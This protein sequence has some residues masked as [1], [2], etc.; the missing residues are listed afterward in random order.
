MT[1]QTGLLKKMLFITF[2]WGS[3]SFSNQATAQQAVGLHF[4]L[5]NT[6]SIAAIKS[7]ARQPYY[8]IAPGIDYQHNTSDKFAFW[9]SLGVLSTGQHS[10]SNDLRWGSE[11]DDQG[12]WVPDPNLPHKAERRIFLLY[13]SIQAGVKYYLTDNRIRLFVQPYLEGDAFLSH[14]E[15]NLL[16]LDNGDLNSK[17]SVTEPYV[18]KQNIVFAT[19]A[20]FGGEMEL[21]DRFSLYLLC[22]GKF[23]LTKTVSNAEG[24]VF[25]PAIRL[26]V[27]YKI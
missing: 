1:M 12:N 8:S 16:F 24:S 18:V 15:T 4:A 2:L 3:L 21:G 7:G 14:R 9:S 23:M 17:T 27:L 26:G 22:D 6:Y 5:G 25:I 10:T 20:G 19:G 11:H 13:L